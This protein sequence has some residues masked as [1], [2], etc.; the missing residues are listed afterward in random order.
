MDKIKM[1]KHLIIIVFELLIICVLLLCISH[2]RSKNGSELGT[3]TSTD[4]KKAQSKD[5]KKEAKKKEAAA[6][7]DEQQDIDA[8][9]AG[10]SATPSEPEAQTIFSYPEIEFNPHCVDSTKPTNY[11]ASTDIIVDD[12]ILPSKDDYKPADQISFDVSEKYTANVDG[13]VTFRGNNFRDNPTY[14]YANIKQGSME[15]KWNVATGGVTVGDHSWSGSG[16][17]GQPLI[18]RWPK[19][20]RQHMNM[21]DSAKQK[22]DLVEVIYACMDGYIYFMDLYTGEKTR[23]DLFLGLTFKG[24]GALDPRGYPLMYVGS[25]YDANDKKS[26]AYII[27]L[28]DCSILHEF[29]CVDPFS[30]R[31]QLSFFDSSAL[32]DAETDT[33]IYPG[34]NGLLYLIKLNTKFDEKAG[35]ISIDPK[36]TR[37]RYSGVR[38]SSEKYWLGMED[39]CDI[40]KNYFFACDNGGNLWCLDLN[41]LKLVWAQD[42]LD[43]SNGSPVL[44]IEDGHLYLYVSTSFHIGWRSSTTATIP[45]WKIDAETGEIVW[46]VDYEC[47]TIEGVSGGV[48]STICVGRGEL[49]EYIYVTVA[50]THGTGGGDFVCIKKADGTKQFEKQTAYSWSSPVCVYNTD[51]SGRVLYATADGNLYSVNGKTGEEYSHI[52]ISDGT[53]EASPAVYDNMLVIGTRASKIW[54][55]E[56]Q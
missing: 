42:V 28:M 15:A 39:S 7:E 54:G 11:F 30:L 27:N 19:E 18:R 23:D 31:G 38:S 10:E 34:E 2:V 35:T 37:W 46:Q 52:S 51:G 16:W 29:G 3:A 20:L 49:N 33:L 8:L 32:V 56:L 41:T 5:K 21:Y 22:D 36:T 17:T 6:P 4:A 9:I 40:Y 47:N 50:M 44:S 43:D 53:I 13:V 48:Q 12:N 24:S 55:I 45:I 1:L 26:R 14:G 25:G